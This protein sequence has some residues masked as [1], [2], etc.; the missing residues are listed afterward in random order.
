VAVAA[1]YIKL[2]ERLVLV[3]LEVA[4]LVAI[5]LVRVRLMGLLTQAVVVADKVR[6]LLV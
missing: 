6:S 1:E 4:E 5:I 3:V 2:V